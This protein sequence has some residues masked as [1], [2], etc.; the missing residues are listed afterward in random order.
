MWG[1]T[2]G[3]RG[4]F[5]AIGSHP[6]RMEAIKVQSKSMVC[7]L[8]AALVALLAIGVPAVAQVTETGTI[9]VLVQDSSGPPFPA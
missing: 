9:E 4:V 3:R 1:R 7:S 5:N 2:R 6:D 8:A